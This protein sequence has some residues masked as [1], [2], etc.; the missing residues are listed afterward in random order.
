MAWETIHEKV[1]LSYWRLYRKPKS[2]SD[3]DLINRQ[4]KCI[5][6]VLKKI[7]AKLGNNTD[8][9]GFEVI[10]A[11]FIPAIDQEEI[12][13]KCENVR[14]KFLKIII[15]N[16]AVGHYAFITEKFCDGKTIA[17]Y[18]LGHGYVFTVSF[19]LSHKALLRMNHVEQCFDIAEEPFNTYR[20][21]R[22]RHH[23]NIFALVMT[24]FEN[25]VMEERKSLY[26]LLDR[27]IKK[28]DLDEYVLSGVFPRMKELIIKDIKKLVRKSISEVN[29]NK[30]FEGLVAG[31]CKYK[32]NFD[33]G[34][35]VYF[36]RLCSL[37]F[38]PSEIV[39]LTNAQ[40]SISLIE[41]SLKKIKNKGS[42]GYFG[43]V[44]NLFLMVSLYDAINNKIENI[45]SVLDAEVSSRCVFVTTNFDMVHNYKLK[46]A[47]CETVRCANSECAIL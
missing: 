31:F 7:K 45:Q 1:E 17:E 36:N 38:A 26:C 35:D 2:S 28:A 22:K 41:E 6:E 20:C 47:A 3:S 32:N 24:R 43:R 10:K 46:E 33:E 34:G 18:L 5:G 42:A 44:T 14:I 23:S 19:L 25:D 4:I 21:V 15:D 8:P 30:L 29:A 13:F 9:Y 40:I 12:G 16:H 37:G 39:H 27:V 11:M